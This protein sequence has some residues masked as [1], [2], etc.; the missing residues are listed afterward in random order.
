[1]PR[2]ASVLLIL[3]ALGGVGCLKPLPLRDDLV[4][5]EVLRRYQDFYPAQTSASPE[6]GLV[7]PRFGVPVIAQAGAAFAV[8]LLARPGAVTPRVALVRPDISTEQGTACL[9]GEPST[10]CYPLTL[11]LTE[12]RKMAEGA[13]WQ[14]YAAR[15]VQTPPPG[16]YDVMVMDEGSAVQRSPHSVWLRAD[17]PEQIARP[18]VI[19]LSDLHVGK[20]SSRRAGQILGRLFEVV[21]E[22]N[23]LHPDLV[24]VTG[25]LV[26]RGQTEGLQLGAQQVL[27]HVNAPV[28]VVMGNHDIEFGFFRRPVRRYGAGWVH[29][30][31][32]F[33]PLLHYSVPLGGYDFV[34][35]DS[36]PSVRSLRILT[37][38]LHRESLATLRQ[39]VDRAAA[40][41]R[42]GVV[43]FSHAPSRA[44]LNKS[45]NP[46]GIGFFGR[47][48]QGRAEF[49]RLIIDGGRKGLQV[50]HLA[51]HTHWSDVFDLVPKGKRQSFLPWRELSP[52][53]R[54]LRGSVGLVT[55][56]AAA[57]AGVS[58]KKNARGY[59][60]S[61]IELGGDVP[62]VATVQHGVGRVTECPDDSLLDLAQ[63]ERRPGSQ[64]VGL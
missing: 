6:V 2:L 22:V 9:R 41:G 38:G 7:R 58:G 48:D 32:A 59:G 54:P 10:S 3:S 45:I 47:M 33:H 20:G 27:R 34:G 17:D 29:F 44:V 25:D 1:M 14:V 39:D 63:K 46:T 30:A 53:L 5:D 37:R 35:F 57:H 15:T 23:R 28:L 42:R 21:T 11:S 60:F 61:L 18:R 55:T 24:V 19:H 26:D 4:M 49:E 56:Q 50:L 16:G 12:H 8:E 31:Q 51:G 43:M 52:C 36:G 64:A 40:Q 13:A 62:K